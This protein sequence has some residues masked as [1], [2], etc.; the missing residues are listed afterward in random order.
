M[1]RS[2]I[3]EPEIPQSVIGRLE[4][5][6]KSEVSESLNR[7]NG[8]DL[9]V[10]HKII[11]SNVISVNTAARKAKELG[12]STQILTYALAGEARTA[13]L[14][15]IKMDL[16]H[17][18]AI[19]A[20]GETT[21]TI[22]GTGLGGRNLE[23]ALGAAGAV[24]SLKNVVLV[25]LAT[26]GEDGP[27]EAAGAVVSSEQKLD[28]ALVNQCL[29]NNDSYNYFQKTGGLIITGPTGTNVNDIAFVIGY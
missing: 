23:M 18:F 14:E 24:R 2:Y 7:K 5:G 20:G 15:L 10:Y 26:D 6:H 28:L 19:F 4:R 11:G 27:T 13:G 9:A 25:T 29:E 16:P 17:P 12:F 1:L 8:N 3:H 21:V 22:H